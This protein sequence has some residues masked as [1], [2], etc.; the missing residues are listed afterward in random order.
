MATVA[1]P[2]TGVESSAEA[3]HGAIALIGAIAG[4]LAGPAL[5]HGAVAHPA[6]HPSL[7]LN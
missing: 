6:A 7:R 3:T 2:V 1:F 5:E 4:A